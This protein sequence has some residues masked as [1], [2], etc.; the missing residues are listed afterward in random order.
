MHPRQGFHRVPQTRWKVLSTPVSPAPSRP[1][2]RCYED[3]VHESPN[4]IVEL[5]KLWTRVQIRLLL[6]LGSLD[7]TDKLVDP[8]EEDPALDKRNEAIFDGMTTS[9]ALFVLTWMGREMY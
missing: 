5:N 9:S 8:I 4:I 3:D 7:V 6:R 1:H 2:G